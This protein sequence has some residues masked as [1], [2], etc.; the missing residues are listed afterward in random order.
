[1]AVREVKVLNKMG[2]LVNSGA[3]NLWIVVNNK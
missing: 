1:M 3:N 2:I